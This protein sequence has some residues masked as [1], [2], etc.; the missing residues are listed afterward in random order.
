MIRTSNSLL[1]QVDWKNLIRYLIV[2][3]EMSVIAK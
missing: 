1:Y 3:T 2:F